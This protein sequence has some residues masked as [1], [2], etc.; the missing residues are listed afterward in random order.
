MAYYDA[1]KTEWALQ[2]GTTAQ[3]LAAVNAATVAGPNVDVPVQSVLAYLALNLKLAGLQTYASGAGTTTGVLA[4]RELVA[5]FNMPTFTTFQ[6]SNP[7]VYAQMQVFL[8]ALAADAN[9]GIVSA[10]ETALLA[11]AATTIPWWQ[12][13]G[14]GAPISNNDL[15]AA[16]GLT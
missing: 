2:S 9:S 7:T 6:M 4:A 12:S 16:G 13:A 1:L 14:Y 15:V 11:L 8:Q 3:K 5:L 10:D